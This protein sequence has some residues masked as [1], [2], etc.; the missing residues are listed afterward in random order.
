MEHLPAFNNFTHKKARK[1]IDAY[2]YQNQANS[3]KVKFLT[4][5]MFKIFIAKKAITSWARLSSYW[6]WVAPT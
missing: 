5:A 2:V 6:D 1:C 4:A 3:N